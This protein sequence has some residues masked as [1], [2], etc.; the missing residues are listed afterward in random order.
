MA[1]LND[2]RASGYNSSG[3]IRIWMKFGALRVYCLGLALTDF[4]RDLRRSESGTM[5]GNFVFFCEVNNARLCRFLVSQISQNLH[6]RCVSERW[7]ILSENIY[8]NLPVRGLFFRKRQILG[9]R[10][11]RLRTSGRDISEMVTNLGKSWQVGQPTECWLS[12]CTVGINSKSFPW[13]AGCVQETTFLVIAGSSV[14]RCRRN[15]AKSFVWR[16]Q[17]ANADVALLLTL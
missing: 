8:E 10:L 7:W 5:S 11:Q 12:T 1:R 2:V 6:A 14:W 16:R 15:V 9:D 13:P 3:S 4:G 17:Q